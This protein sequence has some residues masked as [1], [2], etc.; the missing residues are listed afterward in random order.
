MK[1]VDIIFSANLNSI[2]GPVQTLKRVLT[3]HSFFQE[4]NYDLTVFSLDQ[5]NGISSIANIQTNVVDKGNSAELVRKIKSIARFFAQHSF[6]YDALRIFYLL[7]TPLPLI[8]NYCSLNRDP[9]IMVFH[10]L[11]DCYCYLRYAKN[12][13]AKIALFIH[14]D[15]ANNSMLL[16]Y[17]PK[18]RGTFVEKRLDSITRFVI[19]H[20][21]R[22]VSISEIGARNFLIEYPQLNGRISLVINGISDLDENQKKYVKEKKRGS[23]KRNYRLISCGTINGRKGQWIVI[24]ALH[25]LPEKIKE[26]IEYTVVG[27]GPQRM[28]LENKVEGYSLQ[29]CVR[30]VGAVANVDVYRYLAESNIAILMSRN[31]GLPLSLIEALRCG[32]AGISTKVAGIPEVIL[33]GHNGVLIEP[34]V[35]QLFEVLLHINDYPWDE[36]GRKSRVLFEEKYTFERMRRNYLSLLESL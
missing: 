4:K 19:D 21:D 12:V 23:F 18:A 7:R 5:M 22:V 1:K 34:D 29:G 25:R 32:L 35:N 24:E 2:I 17:F 6:L 13:R 28:E 3:S 30:F 14:A 36:M 16:E 20:V 15:S 9:Q 31:E 11:Y 10:N 26:Q 27:D 33:D 8:K